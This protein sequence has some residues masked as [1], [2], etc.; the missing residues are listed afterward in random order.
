VSSSFSCLLFSFF[1]PNF[2]LFPC[3]FASGMLLCFSVSFSGVSRL[4]VGSGEIF[5]QNPRISRN[6]RDFATCSSSGF[7]GFVL[8]PVRKIWGSG[9]CILVILRLCF[10]HVFFSSS[11]LR[12]LGFRVFKRKKE[13]GDLHN[14]GI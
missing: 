9:F 12:L 14:S 10:I 1:P 6:S 4:G 5:A 11:A 8:Q 13:D 2:R 7:Q 3:S